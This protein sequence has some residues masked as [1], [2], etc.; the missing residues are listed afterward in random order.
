M[1]LRCNICREEKS[2]DQFNRRTSS[3]SG[4][5]AHCRACS[6]GKNKVRYVEHRDVIR[7]Q[8]R[9]NRNHRL[10]V[11]RAYRGRNQ[12]A[13]NAQ[14]RQWQKDNQERYNEISRRTSSTRR[15]R[16]YEVFDEEIVPLIVLELDDGVCGICGDDVNP[17][18]YHIDHIMPLAQGGRHNYG[19]VQVAHPKCNQQ[20]GHLLLTYD[21][22][23]KE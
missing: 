8:N 1:L 21:P 20:K 11:Q 10:S 16:L 7:N 17:A 23:D 13:I 6:K 12:E 18:D 4:R 3:R 9:L 19:N 2:C 22:L 5:Q 14:T 15:A